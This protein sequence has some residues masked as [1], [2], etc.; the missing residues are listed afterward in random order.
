MVYGYYSTRVFFATI[1]MTCFTESSERRSLLYLSG[2]KSP[3]VFVWC[4]NWNI[5]LLKMVKLLFW[6]IKQMK[7]PP[8]KQVVRNVIFIREVYFLHNSFAECCSQLRFPLYSVSCLTALFI[9]LL[10][11]LMYASDISWRSKFTFW[12]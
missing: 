2:W 10:S 7:Y 1:F 5:F 11:F 3:A 4:W 12:L 9:S 6:M 8:V